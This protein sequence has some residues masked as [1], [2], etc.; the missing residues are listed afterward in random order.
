VQPE[1]V[2]VLAQDWPVIG[3]KPEVDVQPVELVVVP[4]VVLVVEPPVTI[5]FKAALVEAPTNPVPAV[6][7]TGAKISAAF[8]NWNAATAALVLAPK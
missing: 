6:K 4:V 3:L 7:P 1:T 5:A 2:D 8:F